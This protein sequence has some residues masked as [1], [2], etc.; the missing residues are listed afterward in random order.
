MPKESWN[1]TDFS[2]GFNS[3]FEK[4]DVEDSESAFITDLISY[5]AGALKLQGCFID[6]EGSPQIEG[7]YV[8]NYISGVDSNFY[9][10][11][12]YSFY[13]YGK[14]AIA[15]SNSTTATI[16]SASHGLYTGCN[17]TIIKADGFDA[18]EPS[19]TA[20]RATLG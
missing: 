6:P 11:P 5:E 12:G 20:L 9:M 7:F 16:T 2:G 14:G 13:K 8:E 10:Q 1:I 19:V 3:L 15:S 17:I 18:V 4:R